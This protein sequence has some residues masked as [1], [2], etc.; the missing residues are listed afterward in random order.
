[1]ST[2]PVNLGEM[3]LSSTSHCKD[4]QRARFSCCISC[5]VGGDT[6]S[7]RTTYSSSLILK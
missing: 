7:T 4:R 3:S 1:M 5:C 2:L 6:A